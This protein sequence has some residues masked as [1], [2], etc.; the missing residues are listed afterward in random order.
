MKVELSPQAVIDTLTFRH[1]VTV[2]IHQD[3]VG[4]TDNPLALAVEGS[5]G[6][7][8]VIGWSTLDYIH[9]MQEATSSRR[10]ADD[11]PSEHERA[12][13]ETLRDHFRHAGAKVG[14]ITPVHTSDGTRTGYAFACRGHDGYSAET[15]RAIVD[16]YERWA[17][18]EVYFIAGK[19]AGEDRESAVGFIGYESAEAEARTLGEYLAQQ[20]GERLAREWERIA[21]IYS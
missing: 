5:D 3:E 8:D 7:M 19:V 18:G 20:E 12:D 1:G 10:V 14:T 9:P 15:V 11:I 13:N 17:R 16:E 6:A 4:F 21:H 2:E